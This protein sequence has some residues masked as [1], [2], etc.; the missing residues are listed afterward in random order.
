MAPSLNQTQTD[1]AEVLAL[2]G[3]STDDDAHRSLLNEMRD[4]ED[5]AHRFMRTHLRTHE[6]AEVK[7]LAEA[8]EAAQTIL[9][10]LRTE[11]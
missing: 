5:A 3:H 10:S 1:V 4:I 6:F 8:A 11:R 9:A 2:F 7:A